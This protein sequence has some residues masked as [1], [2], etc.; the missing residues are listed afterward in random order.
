MHCVP[1]AGGAPFRSSTCPQ[2]QANPPGNFHDPSH[3]FFNLFF[4]SMVTAVRSIL[5]LQYLQSPNGAP[6]SC[7]PLFPDNRQLPIPHVIRHRDAQAADNMRSIALHHFMNGGA[8]LPWNLEAG[9]NYV[10]PTPAE[11]ATPFAW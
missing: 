3:L 1:A 7:E 4:L 5:R 6:Q 9:F 2:A 8:R 10:P 11:W